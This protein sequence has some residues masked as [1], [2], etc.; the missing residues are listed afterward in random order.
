VNDGARPLGGWEHRAGA[1]L[2]HLEP[3]DRGLETVPDA[4]PPS[5]LWLRNT[6]KSVVPRTS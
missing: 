5:Y 6:V 3:N 2:R 1:T 4:R